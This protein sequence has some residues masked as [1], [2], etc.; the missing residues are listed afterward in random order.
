MSSEQDNELD[1]TFFSYG[2]SCC[3][4]QRV[5]TSSGAISH[6]ISCQCQADNCNSDLP[7]LKIPSAGNPQSTTAKRILNAGNPPSTAANRISSAGFAPQPISKLFIVFVA[8]IAVLSI[9][10]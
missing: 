2:S 10:R 6:Y 9:I 7:P 1:S 5:T 4:S 3:H 8:K